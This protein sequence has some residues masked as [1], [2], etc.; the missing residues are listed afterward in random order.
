MMTT[1]TNNQESSS[2]LSKLFAPVDNASLTLYRIGWGCVVTTWAWDYLTSGRVRM[3]YV[4]PQFHFTYRYFD[5]VHPWPGIGMYLHFIALILLGVAITLG[6]RYRLASFLFAIGFTYVFLLEQTNYQNHY[7]LVTL[8]SWVNLLLPLHR[9][10]SWD[11]RHDPALHSDTTPRWVLWCVRFHVGVP[12]FFGGLAKLIPDWMLGE[13]MRTMLLQK[14]DTPIVGALFASDAAGLLF[15]WGGIFLDLFIVPLLMY[16]RTRALAFC[17]GLFFHLSNSILFNIHIFPWFM[18]IG[19][20]IF[21]EPDWPRRF[22]GLGRIQVPE[23]NAVSWRGLSQWK[24]A[25]VLLACVYICFHL[26]WPLRYRTYAGDSSWTEQ[27][28][29]FSWRMMLRGKTGGIRFFVT[30]P[31]LK[32]T[33]IPDLRGLLSEEQVGKFPKNPDWVLQF[34]HFLASEYKNKTGR[35]VEVRALVLLSLNGRK[36]QLLIDPNA[37]LIALRRGERIRPWVLPNEEPLRKQPWDVPLLEWERH[38][39]LPPLEFLQTAPLVMQNPG[40]PIADSSEADNP[41]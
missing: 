1:K 8:L 39:Q 4:E 6:F 29:F 25:G 19:T 35:E 30:D 31:E 18:I 33:F 12:Y 14:S 11:A 26:T 37:N 9:N 17:A 34:A 23:A 13:P 41:S 38:V 5:W 2:L 36:P 40:R 24:K 3:L 27:G 15:S 16:R 20:T 21:F 28:H 7:Y 32:M 10:L 22:F